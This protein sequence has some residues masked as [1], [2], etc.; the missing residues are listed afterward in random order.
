MIRTD[1][2]WELIPVTRGVWNILKINQ[3]K[4]NLDDAARLFDQ[5]AK[6]AEATSGGNLFAMLGKAR[7]AY[8][9]K[10]FRGALKLY[11]QVL[12]HRPDMSPDPRIGIGLC[13]WRLGMKLDAR[14]AWE[15]SLSLRPRNLYINALLG[16]SFLDEAFQ[17]RDESDI[18]IGL[19]KKAIKCMEVAYKQRGR[20]PLAAVR[21]IAFYFSKKQME[22]V[23]KL[24]EKVIES[25][26]ANEILCEAYFWMARAAHQTVGAIFPAVTD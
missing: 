25:S 7:V 5:A 8:A 22:L 6:H 10:S 1:A 15:R 23:S 17:N 14:A 13:F 19:Y 26:D 2:T 3:N 21:L 18:F 12:S 11:Q 20:S 24:A 16:I 4:A 9:R